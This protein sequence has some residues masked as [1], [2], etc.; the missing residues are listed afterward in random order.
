VIVA[1]VVAVTGGARGLGLATA[2]AFAR[3]GARVVIGDVDLD[4]ARAAAAA[5]GASAIR[6][7]V[8]DPASF[9]AFASAAGEIDVLVNNAGIAYGGTFLDT[10]AAMRDLQIDINLRGVVNGMAAVLPGMVERGRG[11][12]VNVA[13]L[14]GR[15]A[16]PGAAIYT[17]TK[18]AVVGL[19]EAVR[20]ELHGS[21]VRATAVLPTFVRTRMTEGLPLDRL[22]T[23]TPEQVANAVLTAVRRGGPATVVVPRWL[24]GLPR[25]TA[26]T[27]QSIQDRLRRRAA[28]D[29]RG[30]ETSRSDYLTRLRDMLPESDPDRSE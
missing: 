22:P 5:I 13:S 10:P 25:L 16:T 24:A 15:V 1:F 4:E 27:P 9:A 2:R 21:G 6:L 29:S 11:H 23:A 8:R 12:V 20:A 19:T 18:F 17:A 14:A 28:G 3:G 30:A 7:D 26:L